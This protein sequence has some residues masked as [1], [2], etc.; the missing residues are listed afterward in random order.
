MATLK[1][2]EEISADQRLEAMQRR[3]NAQAAERMLSTDVST[4]CREVGRE[5][6]GVAVVRCV[7]GEIGGLMVG[8]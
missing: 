6:G 7:A 3:S 5:A 4:L 1:E 2:V 8:F